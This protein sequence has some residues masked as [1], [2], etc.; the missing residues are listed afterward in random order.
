[1]SQDN[2]SLRAMAENAMG[3][4]VAFGELLS[5]E[6]KQFLLD[7]GVVRSAL[8]GEV[9][10]RQGSIDSQVYILVIGEVEVSE[11]NA[12]QKVVLANLQRGEIFGEISALFHLPRIS[13]V[14]VTRSSV[15]LE[16]PGDV[17]QKLLNKHALLSN[18]ILS[19]YQKRITET[20]LRMVDMFR[21]LPAEKLQLLADT[22]V[23][24]SYQAGTSI[25]NEHS[26]GEALY[27]MIHG[28]V[29]VSR[30]VNDETLNL[31]LLRTGEYFGEWSLLTGAPCS[32]TVTAMEQVEV[33][34]IDCQPFLQFI[35]EN[36]QIRDRIDLV[37][38]NRHA[39]LTHSAQELDD[40][41]A[42]IEQ[43]IKSENWPHKDVDQA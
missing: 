2:Q 36:P 21:Y 27:F 8:P 19:R 12:E 9:I 33:L 5:T 22:A 37:A 18:A 43:I 13:T 10:C 42:G 17:L 30:E 23:L 34:Q 41:V 1:M 38:Y 7:H 32:A 29:R 20:A 11:G 28:T 39:D 14:T 35:Q 25:I 26:A 6:E 24:R 4:H 31:A 3:S 15:M 16:I 40:I